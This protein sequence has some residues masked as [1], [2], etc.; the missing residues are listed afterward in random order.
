MSR[1]PVV[2]TAAIVVI[3]V[4]GGLYLLSRR[5]PQEIIQDADT[6]VF[7]SVST[8][9]RRPVGFVDSQ[10]YWYRIQIGGGIGVKAPTEPFPASV[11]MHPAC[12]ATLI[13]EH[14]LLTA[15]HCMGSRTNAAVK[16]PDN[17]RSKG[18]CTVFQEG[19]SPDFSIDIAL[20]RMETAISSINFETLASDAI[21]VKVGDE[22]MLTGF[23]ANK[24]FEETFLTGMTNVSTIDGSILVTKDKVFTT[25]GDSGGA[26]Y[27]ISTTDRHL[28]AVNSRVADP[29]SFATL[30]VPL[31]AT[32]V[33]WQQQ[34]STALKKHVFIC[35]YDDHPSCKPKS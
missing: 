5:Q 30:V 20:C 4:A 29:E 14:V 13:G 34:S 28:I 7:E 9:P 17:Q 6:V 23:G 25:S 12:S 31:K 35:G 21:T 22:V 27:R 19:T 18:P 2:V 24:E 15:G 10:R 16:L 26:V 3:V 8:L 32:I 33:N 11:F 1:L